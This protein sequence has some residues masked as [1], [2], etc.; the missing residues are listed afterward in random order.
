M[1]DLAGKITVALA[2]NPN[3]GKTTIFNKITGAR[4]HVGNYPGVTVEKKEGFKKVGSTEVTVVDLPGTYSLTAFSPEEVVARNFIVREAPDVVVNIIDAANLERNLYLTIQLMEL[5]RPMVLAL[6]MID[7]IEESGVQVDHQALSTVL[8][9]PVVRTVGSSGQGIEK[10]LDT[11]VVAN[12]KPP[13]LDLTYHQAIES[14]VAGLMSHMQDIKQQL[15]F[16]LRWI[17]LRLL[18]NDSETMKEIQGI[19]GGQFIIDAAQNYRNDIV[20]ELEQEPE[21]LIAQTRY[22][23]IQEIYRH[24]ISGD[25]ER[26]KFSNKIDA[27]LTHRWLGLPIFFL[28]M[29]LVFYLVFKLGSF[30]QEWIEELFGRFGEYISAFIT[31][32]DLNSLIVDGVIGGVGS[33]LSFLP[34][35]LLLF[36]AISLLED[37]GYMAR[38][39]FVMDKVMN[40]VGLHGK[41]FI[42]LLLGFGCTVPA[43]LGTRTLENQRDRIITILVT[44]FM[45]CSAR[46]PVYM[47][48]TAA[49]FSEA[50]AGTVLFAIYSLGILLAIVMA[51][52]FRSVLFSGSTEPFVMELPP[53][54]V[55]V[56]KNILLTMCERSMLYIKKAGTIILA[57]TLLVWFATNYPRDAVFTKSYDEALAAVQTQYNKNMREQVLNPLRIQNIDDHPVLHEL[58]VQMAQSGSM[59][60]TVEDNLA[61]LSGARFTDSPELVAAVRN[62]LTIQRQY[63]ET[64]SII[65][66]QQAKDQLTSSFAGRLGKFIEPLIAPLG[67]DWKIGVGLIAGISAKEILVSTLATI[68]SMGS[69]Q[70]GSFYLKEALV[71]DP[72]MNMLVA[73]SLMIFVLVYAPCLATIVVIKR[74]TKSWKWAAFSF[75]YSTGLAWVLSFIVF[76]GGKMLGL[77]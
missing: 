19:S 67:F 31:D 8:G 54:H 14:A 61:G 37:T 25:L 38:A 62:Y 33:V 49:F 29:W 50:A 43:I 75:A 58:A 53:Y 44:P 63:E 73:L 4:Q 77:V 69:G 68:Y 22:E 66:N 71:A 55:P 42:P 39:A 46:L 9:M 70:Q 17:S 16:P 48:L 1:I 60:R 6:N 7:M 72:N 45:S 56:L 18:E 36:L 41:S 40:R 27:I 59:R 11:I 24:I 47:V 30:P 34:N 15:V 32:G 51:R 28:L 57:V 23:Y 2:G 35:I 74:E 52:F 13:H 65:N 21:W 20:K 10:L 26:L 12:I 3:C 5:E 76:Q 64:K